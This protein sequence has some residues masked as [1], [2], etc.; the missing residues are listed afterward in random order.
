MFFRTVSGYFV[1]LSSGK[2]DR[3]F[4]KCRSQHTYCLQGKIK[5]LWDQKYITCLVSESYKIKFYLMLHCGHNQT[6]WKVFFLFILSTSGILSVL[7]RFGTGRVLWKR[8]SGHDWVWS[9]QHSMDVSGMLGL[10]P[11]DRMQGTSVEGYLSLISACFLETALSPLFRSPVRH[12]S[13]SRLFLTAVWSALDVLVQA[14]H[15]N[16]LKCGD[17]YS[18][19]VPWRARG[20]D[21]WIS[22]V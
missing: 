1:F 4:K 14:P 20:K 12:L 6:Y 10:E 17:F 8:R 18:P 5:E 13:C 15:W 2:D 3:S 19:C 7:W 9:P 16:Y 21:C 22:G 11:A